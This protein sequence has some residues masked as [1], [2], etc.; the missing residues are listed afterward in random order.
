MIKTIQP[1]P[2]TIVEHIGNQNTGFQKLDF[3]SEAFRIP[4]RHI[5]TPIKDPKTKRAVAVVPAVMEVIPSSY[6]ENFS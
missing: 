3:E 2:K 4:I 1:T 5:A 6:P